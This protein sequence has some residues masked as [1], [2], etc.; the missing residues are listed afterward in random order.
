MLIL[1]QNHGFNDIS[2]KKTGKNRHKFILCL[3]YCIHCLRRLKSAAIKI[4]FIGQ[5]L[6][7]AATRERGLLKAC[8]MRPIR[9]DVICRIKFELL[10]GRINILGGKVI[11]KIDRLQLRLIREWSYEYYGMGMDYQPGM[12]RCPFTPGSVR[13]KSQYELE[14]DKGEDEIYNVD[15][16]TDIEV[17]PEQKITFPF[18]IDISK[19]QE[20][21][22]VQET[23]KLKARADIPFARDAVTEHEIKI[24]FP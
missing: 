4:G 1:S 20:E 7:V 21:K 22:G 24:F 11:Q 16:E 6:Q 18:E 23:W 9:F 10:R 8:L 17:E 15:L 3:R 19:I 2:K 13:V 14:E 5:L 12:D